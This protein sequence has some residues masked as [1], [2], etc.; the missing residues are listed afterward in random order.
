MYTKRFGREED[1]VRH[2]SWG[3]LCDLWLFGDAQDIPLLQNQAI[4]VMVRKIAEERNLPTFL[5]QYV[6]ENTMGT[7]Q[8]PRLFNYMHAYTGSS[9]TNLDDVARFPE[10]AMVDILR[11]IWKAED[12][13]CW[14][15]YQVRKLDVCIYHVR[16][17]GVSCKVSPQ[18][19]G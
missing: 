14:D 18:K 11:Q 2:T 17:E 13:D 19:D 6:Y 8:L 1:E 4:D 3:T 9:E 12:T 5:L 15:R 10:D 16:E 7:A